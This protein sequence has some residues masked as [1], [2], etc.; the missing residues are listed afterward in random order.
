MR[1]ILRHRPSSTLV[2]ACL[3]VSIALGGTASAAVLIT[4][5][6][7]KDGSVA[8][9]DITNRSLTGLDVRDRSLTPLDFN[10]SLEGP[11]G[12]AGPAGPQGLKGDRG[13]EGPAGASG[14]AGPAGPVGEKGVPGTPGQDATNLFAFVQDGDDTA[15]ATLQ[16]G[17]GAV[18]A[19]DPAGANHA[20]Y[21]YIVSFNR[22][23]QGCVAQATSGFGQYS[24]VGT[25]GGIAIMH[26]KIFGSTVEVFGFRHDGVPKDTGFMLTVFC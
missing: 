22:S 16:Y 4:G 8:G 1:R 12:A 2:I 9:R 7:V 26:T 25:H 18:S 11:A 15:T 20:G 24:S 10:G 14:P 21:P 17:K 3:A 5:K 6:Q 13:Q 19:S 23:L